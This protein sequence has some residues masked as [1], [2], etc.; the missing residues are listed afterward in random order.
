M[1]SAIE[2]ML[3]KYTLIS[4]DDYKNALKEIVQEIALLGLFR[5]GFF[6]KAAFNGGTA[7]RIFYGLDRF[8]EDLDFSLLIPEKDFQL[9]KYTK[10]IEQELGAF[11]FEMVIQQ[12]D[13]L[14]NSQIKSAFIKGGTKI[15]LLKINSIK[16]PVTGVH[17]NE[18]IKIKIEVDIDP[19]ANAK[20]DVKYQL[21]PVPYSVRLFS[22]STLFAS[23]L[24]AILCRNWGSRVKGRDFYDFI[25]YLS[26]GIEYNFE[27]LASRMKQ[28]NHLNENSFLTHH[29]VIDLLTE[30]F[31]VIDFEQAKN[32]VMPFINDLSQLNMW[33]KDFFIQLTNTKL[34]SE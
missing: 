10:F 32:D 7:L 15:H 17:H 9:S 18:Q 1:Q 34:L 5:S 21:N 30:R 23:K 14:Q 31:S 27:H 13:K 8:S 19:P 6:S 33:S 29:N 20:Y 22:Q 25:W 2:T 11:G 16:T 3:K 24:H 28:T 12:I 26:K 4:N